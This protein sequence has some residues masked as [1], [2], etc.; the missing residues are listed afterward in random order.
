VF[1]DGDLEIRRR[2][3]EISNIRKHCLHIFR[4]FFGLIIPEAAQ[5]RFIG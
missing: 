2:D 1:S 5:R 4:I 3:T